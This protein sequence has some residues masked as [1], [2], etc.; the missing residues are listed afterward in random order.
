MV[1]LAIVEGQK[2][3]VKRNNANRERFQEKGY[4]FTKLG[5]EFEVEV[6]DLTKGSH[7]R[8]RIKCDYCGEITEK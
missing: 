8:V 6:S 2:V 7:S 3:S 1:G 5:E 4:K